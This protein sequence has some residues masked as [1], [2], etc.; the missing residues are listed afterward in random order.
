MTAAACCAPTLVSV[1]AANANRP[2]PFPPLPI[3]GGAAATKAAKSAA[4]GPARPSAIALHRPLWSRATMAVFEA[5]AS[6]RAAARRQAEMR[7]LARLDRHL[8]RDVGLEERV[9][10]RPEPAWQMLERARW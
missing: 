8:L 6:W 10:S 1:A 4:Q 9:P 2:T 3:V 7:A 5:W